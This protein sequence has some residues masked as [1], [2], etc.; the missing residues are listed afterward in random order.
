MTYAC[1]IVFCR[2]PIYSML[3]PIYTCLTFCHDNNG[4]NF[5]ISG[6]QLFILELC[7]FFMVIFVFYNRNHQNVKRSGNKLI[8]KVGLPS[9]GV[10]LDK[11]IKQG[12]KLWTPIYVLE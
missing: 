6:L 4:L 1:E 2:V 7:F 5:S 3:L 12:N 9:N 10:N 8:D 11:I